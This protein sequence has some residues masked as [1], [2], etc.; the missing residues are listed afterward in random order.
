[1]GNL[2]Y[3]VCPWHQFKIKK[4]LTS[5]DLKR[6]RNDIWLQIAKSLQALKKFLFLDLEN[7]YSGAL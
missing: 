5:E 7:I 4:G 2:C 3:D 6:Y 1:M